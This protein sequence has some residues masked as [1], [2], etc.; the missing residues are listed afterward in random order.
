MAILPSA[1][2]VG[3]GTEKIIAWMHKKFNLS[4][5]IIVAI[6]CILILLI[7]LPKNLR[8]QEEDKLV[9]KEIGES[10]ALLDGGAGEIELMTLGETIRWNNYF[11]NL[12]VSGAPCPEKYSDWRNEKGIVASS[13]KDFISDIRAK[14]ISYV[15]WEEKHW[16][17]DTF[18]F[19]KSIQ[20]DD[21]KQL[22]E[23][24]HKDTGRIILYRVL[25]PR[26]G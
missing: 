17:P 15:V 14:K 3:F 4:A 26:K 20:P 9:F 6:L 7:T 25:Y 21:L 23:W 2:F 19:L 11:A 24:K 1:I 5:S 13:Y 8:I 18:S 22:K 10:I 16:P 12:H